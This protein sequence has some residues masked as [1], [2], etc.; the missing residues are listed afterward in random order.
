MYSMDNK[1]KQLFVLDFH[2]H[3]VILNPVPPKLPQLSLKDCAQR[4]GVLSYTLFKV[5]SNPL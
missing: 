3:T 4:S 1:D 5:S 2:Q